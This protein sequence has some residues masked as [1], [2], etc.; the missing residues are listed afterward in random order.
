MNMSVRYG[1]ALLV[2]ALLAIATSSAQTAIAQEQP[3]IVGN[4]KVVSDKVKDVSSLEA[5]KKSYIKEGMTDEQKAMA[6]WESVMSHQVQDAPPSEFLQNENTLYDAIK[7]FNVY[8]Y[9]YCGVAAC[10]MSSLARYVGL[11]ARVWTIRN[12]V[13]PEI[14]WDDQWHMLDASFI[15]YFPTA[16]GKIASVG[17]IEE[18]VKAWYKLHPECFV[19][20]QG[21]G[22]KLMDFQKAEGWQGWKKGPE[23]LSKCPLFSDSGW[24]PAN[25]HGWSN[26]MMAYDGSACNSYEAGYSMGYKVNIGL[27]PGETLTRNWSNKKLYANMDGTAGT[28]GAM[29]AKPGEGFLAYSPKYGDLAPGRLGNGTLEYKPPLASLARSAWRYENLKLAG[30]KPLLVAGDDSKQGILEIRMPSSYVYLTGEVSIDAAVGDAGSVG[31]YFSDNNGLDWKQVATIDKSG[32]QKIDLSKLVL[33][34]YD[35]RL[36]LVLNGKGTGITALGFHHDIQ[37]SQRPLPALAEGNNTITFSAGPQEG[38]ISVEGSANLGNKGKQLVWKDFKPVLKNIH[39]DLM[40]DMAAGT[41]E[42]TY[43]VDTPGDV[44]GL[45]I[46]TYYRARDAKGG[47]DVQCSYDG[48]KTFA[49]VSKCQGPTPWNGNFVQLKDIPAGTKSVQVK[50]LGTASNNATMIFNHRI[51]ADY[52]LPN[53]GFAPVKV[54]YLWEEGGIQKKDEHIANKPDETW[55]IKCD[56]KPTMKSIIL[57]L[58]K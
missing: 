48:G 32:Q 23:I 54:T 5:W 13:V 44:T 29:D 39:D 6:I 31:V 35:Y 55:T 40:V 12:H 58:A 50:W 25:T 45:S 27:R 42:L 15:D 21:D 47:W 28:P 57:E 38:T 24:L 14:M 8:G 56:S 36:R 52:K 34:R 17:Q 16:D 3:A 7:M 9:S 49:S 46:L 11:K 20:G 19:N 30:A 18:G 22:N 33:R 53:S 51:D 41:G 26:M 1:W 37:H 43:T 4:V 2:L 10:E